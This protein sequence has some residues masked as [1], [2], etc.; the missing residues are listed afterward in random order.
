MLELALKYLLEGY[1]VIPVGKNKIPLISWKPYQDKKATPEEVVGWWTKNPT[2]QIGIVTGKI[3]DLTVVD[4]EFDGDL[5]LIKDPTYTINTGGGGKHFYFK[6]EKEFQN[7]VRIFPSV[8]IRGTGGYVVACGSVM[9]KGAYTRFNDLKVIKMSPETKSMLLGAKKRELPWNTPSIE[10]YEPKPASTENMEY[11]GAGSGSRNDS[12]T[13]FAGSI[14]AKLHPSLWGTIGIQLFEEANLKNSPPLPRREIDLIWKSISS[15]E[16][17]QNPGGRDYTPRSSSSHQWGPE[18]KKEEE[19]KEETKVDD[20]DV[21]EEENDPKDTLH[22]SEIAKLQKIDSDHTYPIDMPPFDDALLGG[23]SL[24][25]VVVVAG[26]T[27]NGKTTLM[28]DWSVTISSGGAEEK[29]EKLPSLWFSYEVLARPLWK[30]FQSM[31]ASVNTPVYMPRLNEC[32]ETE[33]VEDVIEK[34]IKK[35]GIK[36]VCIDHLGFLRAPKGSYANAADAITN[37]VRSLKK[38][39]VRLGLII[40]LPV[41]IKK[42]LSKN[43]DLNDIK[44]SSGIAQEADTVFFISRK[45]DKSG[46]QTNDADVW[47]VKNRKTGMSVKATLEFNF[48]RYFYDPEKDKK[49]NEIKRE[50]PDLQEIF[51][52]W[53]KPN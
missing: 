14:T 13:V 10:T 51:N 27:G 23:H 2:A 25:E 45:K 12:M 32:G 15:R 53:N 17:S 21:T 1:S 46:I 41:H 28:Q 37:T 30:K 50:E 5:N 8:D 19:K 38:L 34:A 4:V 3:S 47:L 42:T 35:W 18:P 40:F 43:P 44:D 24:G 7:A 33:W 49:V 29:R 6:F 22:V 52:E 16:E 11:M 20:E 9:Q 48:G 31:G 39:A 36:V 26:L